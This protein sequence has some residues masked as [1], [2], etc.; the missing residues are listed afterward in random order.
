MIESGDAEQAI[1]DDENQLNDDITP[2][3]FENKVYHID[4]NR[5]SNENEIEKNNEDKKN[6]NENEKEKENKTN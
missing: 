6:E 5:N 1:I 2:S 3:P 4:Y